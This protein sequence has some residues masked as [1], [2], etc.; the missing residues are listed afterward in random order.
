[1]QENFPVKLSSV[2][3]DTSSFERLTASDIQS[4]DRV[5]NRSCFPET[6]K[7]NKYDDLSEIVWNAITIVGRYDH[8]QT[9]PNPSADELIQYS[10]AILT[11]VE[12]FKTT[13]REYDGVDYGPKLICDIRNLEVMRDWLASNCTLKFR[14]N[15]TGSPDIRM[16]DV[17]PPSPAYYPKPPEYWDR[18]AYAEGKPGGNQAAGGSGEVRTRTGARRS[19][20]AYRQ[21]QAT[22]RLAIVTIPFLQFGVLANPRGQREFRDTLHEVFGRAA[23][24]PAPSNDERGPVERSHGLSRRTTLTDHR[25]M[26]RGRV[27]RAID[28]RHD[29][30]PVH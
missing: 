14:Q 24:A 6:W 19:V 5:M 20:A 22:R 12:P 11:Y 29:Q 23:N 3:R 18:P 7:M 26:R 9:E 4:N 30:H 17:F 28:S 16:V 8:R 10:N 25:Q 27:V 15:K 2:F 13:L 21:R 1:M